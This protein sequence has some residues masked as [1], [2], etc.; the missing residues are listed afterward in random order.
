M[1]LPLLLL[2]LL[3]QLLGMSVSVLLDELSEGTIAPDSQELAGMVTD[4]CWNHASSQ[5]RLKTWVNGVQVASHS[6]TLSEKGQQVGIDTE[7]LGDGLVVVPRESE[8]VAADVD[9]E[10]V[11]S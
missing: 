6:V 9:A 11:D 1:F 2:Q 3:A 4:N 5:A 10:A 7:A 8:G